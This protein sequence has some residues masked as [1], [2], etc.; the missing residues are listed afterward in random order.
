MFRFKS[1]FS[2]RSEN[3]HYAIGMTH[4]PQWRFLLSKISFKIRLF[5]FEIRNPESIT[6][7]WDYS[8]ASGGLMIRSMGI[9]TQQNIPADCVI[10][11]IIRPAFGGTHYRIREQEGKRLAA[12]SGLF[13]NA[14]N[15]D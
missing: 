14:L 9:L 12:I 8:S 1:D 2:W 15:Q 6:N 11:E 13:I 10:S 5:Q 7:L 4:H 3:N